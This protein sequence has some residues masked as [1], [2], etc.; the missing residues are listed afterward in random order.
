MEE[1]EFQIVQV[2]NAL[3]KDPE[4][5]ELID[6]RDGLRQLL[7]LEQE[8]GGGN[9]GK[10]QNKEPAGASTTAPAKS[11]PSSAASATFPIS[12]KPGKNAG[13]AVPEEDL[14]EGDVVLGKWSS[15]NNWYECLILGKE[16]NSYEVV[17]TGSEQSIQVL[18]S[19]Q[20]RKPR[21]NEKIPTLL[22]TQ[23]K[24]V[25]EIKSKPA[26]KYT[27][28][29]NSNHQQSGST[30]ASVPKTAAASTT[31]T[32]ATEKKTKKNNKR[33]E[34]D[35]V[36]VNAW[37]SFAASKG[38]VMKKTGQIVTQNVSSKTLTSFASRGKH[39]FEKNGV[40]E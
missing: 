12:S 31:K 26:S 15:D 36:R 16:G 3:E 14:L 2:T 27:S 34:D 22:T 30:S 18:S 29:N 35:K 9:S 25:G 32:T 23:E 38:K 19:N 11:Q 40:D 24:T 7:D 17:F 37:Q 8:L 33:D 28:A 5:K 21:P 20:V 13:I 4:N 1:Y 39:R 6:L 10:Q